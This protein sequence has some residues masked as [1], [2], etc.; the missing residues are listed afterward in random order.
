[1]GNASLKHLIQMQVNLQM[2]YLND[3]TRTHPPRVGF[4]ESSPAPQTRQAGAARIMKSVFQLWKPNARSFDTLYKLTVPDNASISG[5]LS[6][7]NCFTS[8]MRKQIMMTHQ[9]PPVIALSMPVHSR[10]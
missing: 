8:D 5:K 10:N 9:S 4:G 1:M 6:M 7:E 3:D 2:S